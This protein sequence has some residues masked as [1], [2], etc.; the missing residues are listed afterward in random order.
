MNRPTRTILTP[1]RIFP[2]PICYGRK[3]MS[4][5]NE[6]T[7]TYKSRRP[8][9]L[10]QLRASQPLPTRVS[11]SGDN[12]EVHGLALKMKRSD[13]HQKYQRYYR[14][15]IAEFTFDDWIEFYGH[16][17]RKIASDYHSFPFLPDR[18]P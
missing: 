15:E 18:S 13:W 8:G 10:L 5:E 9:G 4:K 12:E 17:I 6:L 11:F 16:P 14:S 7:V 3:G 1:A 2:A